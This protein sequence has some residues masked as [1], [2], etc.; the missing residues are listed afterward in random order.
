MPLLSTPNTLREGSFSCHC[1]KHLTFEVVHDV[2]HV[3]PE[4]VHVPLGSLLLHCQPPNET[5]APSPWSWCPH[6]GWTRSACLGKSANLVVGFP[7]LTSIHIWHLRPFRTAAHSES[8]EAAGWVG[9]CQNW[10]R[11]DKYFAF[12]DLNKPNQPT[13]A[14]KTLCS[15]ASLSPFFSLLLLPRLPDFFM[16]GSPGCSPGTCLFVSSLS[17]NLIPWL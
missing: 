8:R 1:L 5:V 15:R 14:A 4:G 9:V 17:S 2:C 10:E 12:W 7:W 13:K 16:L 3:T 6:S 11:R